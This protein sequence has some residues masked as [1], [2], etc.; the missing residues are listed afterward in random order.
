MNIVGATRVGEPEIQKAPLFAG[1]RRS[2]LQR[3]INS[4]VAK[5]LDLIAA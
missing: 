3:L 5:K 4:V 2:A 1:E